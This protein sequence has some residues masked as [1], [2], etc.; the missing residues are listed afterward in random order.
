M[1]T[2]NKKKEKYT[3]QNNETRPYEIHFRFFFYQKALDAIG[4]IPDDVTR[5]L[6]DWMAKVS[7]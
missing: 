7:K 2:E 3:T 4:K 6:R 1:T 5:N